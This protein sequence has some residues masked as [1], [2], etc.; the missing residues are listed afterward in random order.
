M[1]DH[2][3]A[4]LDV[5]PAP[6]ADL[7][8]AAA[9]R[10]AGLDA[11]LAP[12][13]VAVVGASDDPT[14]IGGR[15]LRYLREQ[16]YE[17][18]VY[19]VNRRGGTVQGL[20]AY[21]SIT[22]V[23]TTPDVAILAVP[24][25]AVA[26]AVTDCAARGVRAAIILSAGFAETGAAGEE[27]QR[28]VLE[29]AAKA[30]MRLLGPNCLGVLNSGTGFY[31]TFANA[32]DQVRPVPGPVG[33]VSQSGAYGAH[34]T[35]MLAERGVGIGYSVTTGNEVDIDVADAITWMALRPEVRVILAYV[36]G[37]S[38][39]PRFIEALRVARRTRTP[40]VLL[41]VGSSEAGKVAAGTHTASL[42][43]SDRIADA[44]CAQF[45]VHRVTSTEEHVDL[46]YVLARTELGIGDRLGI[47]TISGGAGV[48]L[49]DA[50]ER[51][52]MRVLPLEA[53]ARRSITEHLAYASGANPVDVTAQCLQ[54]PGLLAHSLRTTLGSGQVDAVIAY[55]TTTPM[56]AAFR[57]V[58][59]EALAEGGADRHGKPLV[60]V[61]HAHPDDVRHYEDEGLLVF[62][63][64]ERAVRALGAAA[65]ISRE[66]AR[67]VRDMPPVEATGPL[68]S[69][70]FLNEADAAAEILGAGVPVVSHRLV[71]SPD[72]LDVAVAELGFPLAVKICSADL[73][74][75]SDVG[76][77]ALGVDTVEGLRAAHDRVLAQARQHAPEARIDG[78]LLSAM[79]PSGVDAILGVSRD[80]VFGPV[81]MVGL[82]GT[83][84][85][86]LGDVAFRLAPFD[87]VEARRMLDELRGRAVLDGVRG[88]GPVDV[89]AL[90]GALARL[91]RYA[92]AEAGR[93]LSVDLNPV[94]V[95]P[96]GVVALDALVEVVDRDDVGSG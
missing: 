28:A 34:L 93:V 86:I 7:T 54:D 69:A 30:G 55:L 6:E 36:E 65:R 49:C 20:T 31:G 12:R 81:V 18:A 26:G 74:H 47:V 70:R 59:R 46:G 84:V 43:G 9:A 51:H 83:L 96:E 19:P 95:L 85:E 62:D 41:K 38:D 80:E 77:V 17:G 5:S 24:A 40:V 56:A 53:S 63:D 42:A 2:A 92:S 94:R 66:L 14:R 15:P 60:L 75:K 57:P 23:P 22:D 82:G 4:A 79:A 37:I 48:Q 3:T 71:R 27:L 61:M 50:A 10:L 78:V 52:G 67:E 88:A 72:E 25:A 21:H 35:Y 76:G 58:V 91:S 1:L 68:V 13:S 29:T 87:E 16:G 73:P 33:V 8:P 32:L 90:A 89:A 45:G 39:G 44:V 11:L 64:T